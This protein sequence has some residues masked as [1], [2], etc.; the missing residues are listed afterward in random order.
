MSMPASTA[1]LIIDVQQA[2]FTRPVPIYRAEQLLANINALTVRA[3]AAGAA[4]VYV[5]HGN[6]SFLAEGT[7]G[8]Q[9]HPALQPEPGDLRI[10]KRHGSAF[11]DTPLGAE[12]AARGVRRVAAA[13][14]VPHGCVRATCLDALRLGYAVTLASDA[15]SSYSKDAAALVEEW[16]G[17][18]A[19]AGAQVQPAAEIVFAGL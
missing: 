13:G 14:L 17:R 18:L 6:A 1:L 9:L 10:G 8:W 4:A 16:N 7:Q 2:L 12:L 3:R 19:E 5:Q 11:E 15:H